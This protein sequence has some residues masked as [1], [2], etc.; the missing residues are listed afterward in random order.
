MG[1]GVQNMTLVLHAAGLASGTVRKVFADGKLG[2]SDTFV[3][4]GAAQKLRALV[5]LEPTALLAEMKDLDA[6]E[7]KT[8]LDAF[9][10]GMA[11]A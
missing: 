8:V 3:I 7:A 5:T 1:I 4:F 6:A 10:R 11:E 2:L 9:F